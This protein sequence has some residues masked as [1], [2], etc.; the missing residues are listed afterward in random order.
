MNLTIDEMDGIARVQMV[1]DIDDPER[2]D[3]A[4]MVGRALTCHLRA[5]LPDVPDVAIAKVLLAVADLQSD[6]VADDVRALAMN[7]ALIVSAIELTEHTREE[8]PDHG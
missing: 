4:R 7:N 3:P 1:L 2:T 6:V 5:Q 8:T